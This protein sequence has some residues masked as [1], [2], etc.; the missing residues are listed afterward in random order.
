V[1]RAVRAIEWDTL[2]VMPR[3]EDTLLLRPYMLASLD[4]EVYVVDSDGYIVAL[5]END[6]SVIW[7]AGRHGSGPAEFAQPYWLGTTPAREIMV[8]D[9]LA[10]RLVM[11]HLNGEYSR[12]VSLM[13]ARGEPLAA[14]ALE[15]ASFLVFLGGDSVVAVGSDGRARDRSIQPWNVNDVHGI[16]NQT[17]LDRDPVTGTCVA[18]MLVGDRFLSFNAAEGFGIARKYVEPFAS[19]EWL[20]SSS[21]RDSL[22]HNHHAVWDIEVRNDTLWVLFEGTTEFRRKLLDAY[23]VS[24][25]EYLFTLLLPNRA[26]L[27]ASTGAG[28]VFRMTQEDGARAL[29]ALRPRWLDSPVTLEQIAPR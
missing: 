5:R 8:L 25:G 23:A 1:A 15:D 6:G 2:W 4:S 10:R 19:P 9:Q 28:F 21:G 29:I 12:Y 13:D 26:S 24:T 7:R 17:V 14:C 22:S 16:V 18:A 27:F 20:R 3:E 11:F